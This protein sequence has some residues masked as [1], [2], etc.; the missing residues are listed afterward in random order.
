MSTVTQDIPKA[1][2]TIK[3]LTSGIGLI[4]ESWIGT[5]GLIILLF[6]VTMADVGA[7]PAAF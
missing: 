1:P 5:T 6:W 4:R 3:R 2:S 7:N